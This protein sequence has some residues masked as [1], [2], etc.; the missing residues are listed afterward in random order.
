MTE[1][2]DIATFR[3]DLFTPV[4][5]DECQVNPQVYGAE[6]AYWIGAALARRGVAT[7]YPQSED[8]GWFVEYS[9]ESGA[10][11]ALHC[12]NAEGAR[13]RWVLSLRRFGRGLFGR[14][15]PSLAAA[16]PLI[17]AIQAVLRDE[18]TITELRWLLQDR[19]E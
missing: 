1:P 9:D 5:P 13:D 10:E 4:L 12:C 8:W 11:F 19:P 18:P 2:T 6:L 15:R 16:A 7:S 14:D 17:A 3:S